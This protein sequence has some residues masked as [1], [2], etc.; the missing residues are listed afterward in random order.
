MF[1]S[2]KPIL[3]LTTS[4]NISDVYPLWKLLNLYK[5]SSVSKNNCLVDVSLNNLNLKGNNCETNLLLLNLSSKNSEIL[6]SIKF[7]VDNKIL[8]NVQ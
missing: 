2:K 8:F 7:L 1:I 5:L 3:K 6:K 4:S